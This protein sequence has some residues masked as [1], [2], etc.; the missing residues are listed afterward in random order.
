MRSDMSD[1]LVLRPRWGHANRS[2][3]RSHRRHFND[4]RG[5]DDATT[6]ESSRRHYALRKCLS[7]NFAPFL[8]YLGS[9]VGCRWDDVYADIRS[10]LRIDSATQLHVVQHIK[11][12]VTTTTWYDDDGALRGHRRS[13]PVFIDEVTWWRG[14]FYVDPSGVL[15]RVRRRRRTPPPPP[16]SDARRI[17]D[18]CYVLRHGVWFTV[19]LAP[20]GE[21]R[22]GRMSLN[23]PVDVIFGS[24]AKASPRE[25][26]RFYGRSDVYAVRLGQQ[27]GKRALKR[28]GL[29]TTPV[30]R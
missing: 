15:R 4:R 17:D 23:D 27:L 22:W 14:A 12:F 18:V 1:L 8:R 2:A 26:R 30:R 9:R 5:F 29:T 28:L 13:T 20:L 19:V 7:E 10:V 3:V 24:I 21:G 25:A 16:R 6:H 11:D